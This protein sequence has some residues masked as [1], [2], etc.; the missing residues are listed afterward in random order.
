MTKV[1]ELLRA[2]DL[3]Q[4]SETLQKISSLISAIAKVEILSTE[5]KPDMKDFVNL[6]GTISASGDVSGDIQTLKSARAAILDNT[7]HRF[8]KAIKLL[9]GGTFILQFIDPKIKQHEAPPAL[10]DILQLFP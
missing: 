5:L 9:P 10:V 6:S 4:V 8:H 2:V 3:S 1:V 7:N